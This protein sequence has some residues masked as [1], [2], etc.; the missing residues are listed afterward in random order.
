MCEIQIV[1]IVK[2]KTNIE[3]KFLLPFTHSVG[4]VPCINKENKYIKIKSETKA[5]GKGLGFD[6]TS[7]KDT[8]I[9]LIG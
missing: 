7:K 5:K 3:T 6:L 4:G 2:Y 9:K 8:E 1:T